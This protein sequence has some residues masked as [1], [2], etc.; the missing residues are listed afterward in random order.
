MMVYFNMMVLHGSKDALGDEIKRKVSYNPGFIG[1][2]SFLEPE[3]GLTPASVSKVPY[4]PG[5]IYIFFNM[6][7]I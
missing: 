4:N 1:S 5:F 2:A 3:T 6:G 7:N